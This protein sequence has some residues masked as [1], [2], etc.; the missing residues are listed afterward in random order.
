MSIE[1]VLVQQT[2]LWSDW[3]VM[4]NPGNNGIITEKRT[5]F[6]CTIGLTSE[7]ELPE[8]KSDSTMYRICNNQE[9]TDC[10][11]TGLL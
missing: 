3:I 11:E 1:F 6:V 8:I 4:N 2:T 9:R 5:K 7:H 10:Q